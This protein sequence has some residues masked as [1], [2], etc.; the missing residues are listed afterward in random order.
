MIWWNHYLP[1]YVTGC[2]WKQ[3]TYKRGKND[4]VKAVENISALLLH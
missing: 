2:I 3:V 1:F 4:L